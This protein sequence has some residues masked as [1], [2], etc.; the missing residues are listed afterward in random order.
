MPTMPQ[1]K[2]MTLLAAVTLLE[3]LG[4][5]THPNDPLELPEPWDS[6]GETGHPLWEMV[7]EPRLL[8]TGPG[9][10]IVGNVYPVLTDVSIR[11]YLRAGTRDYNRTDWSDFISGEIENPPH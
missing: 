8:G 2:G 1:T 10:S 6:T 9:G 4:F 5:K 7:G 11:I 3:S